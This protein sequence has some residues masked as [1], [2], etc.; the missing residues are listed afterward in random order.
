MDVSEK[1]RQKL[2]LLPDKPGC[3]IMRDRRGRIV[4]VGKAVSLR[5]RVQSYFRDA[6]LRSASPKLRSL[7]HSVADIDHIVARSEAEAILTEGQLIKDYRP[8]Y[9]VS[10][11]D[12]KRFLLLRA[13]LRAPFPRFRTCRIRRDDGATYFGPYASSAA[14]RAALEFIEKKF[15]LR[16]CAPRIPT[17]EDHRHCINDI[18]RHCSAP[19]VQAISEAE[20]AQR[21]EQACA[22][23]EGKAPGHL[24]ELRGAMQEAA[25]AR[26]FERAA[27]IR[28]TL[29][30]L[31]AVVKQRARVAAPPPVRAAEAMAGVRGLQQALGLER[32]PRLIEA[33]DVSNI[34]GTLAV[35]SLVCSVDGL[36]NRSR[37]RRFRIRT[38][39]GADDPRMIGEAIFRRF[40]RLRE[41]GGEPAS[42][43]LVDG[44]ITQ[45]RAARDALEGTGFGGVPVAGLAKEEERIYVAGREAPIALPRDSGALRV[46]QHIRD[47]AHRFALAYHR[48][49]RAR[50]LRESVLDDIPGVGEQRKQQLLKRFGSVLRLSKASE[51]EIASVS[52][53]GAA[54]ARRIREELSRDHSSEA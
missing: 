12:D 16:K 52:G 10:F 14:A 9:N 45:V 49:L 48:R 54:M 43:V 31:T 47:E 25:T 32:T 36:P 24:G 35:A 42:L 23:L 2:R 5:K 30:M 13:D 3:Y 29:F 15:G 1:I 4:Y 27:A 8:R 53:V 37:Y 28:D 7:V 19:C 18:V 17:L 41:E 20:Y 11:R 6:G 46:L 26:D 34:S 39:G 44:G 51:A 21:V 40:A 50:R 22:F 33:Y 38:V